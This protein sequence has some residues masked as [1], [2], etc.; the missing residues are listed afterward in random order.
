MDA[1]LLFFFLGA[2]YGLIVIFSKQSLIKWCRTLITAQREVIEAAGTLAAA[3]WPIGWP[4]VLIVAWV[5][6]T[7]KL[8]LELWRCTMV[9]VAHIKQQVGKA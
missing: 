4:L 6:A 9:I 1:L 8:C 3:F 5:Q 2:I 7:T